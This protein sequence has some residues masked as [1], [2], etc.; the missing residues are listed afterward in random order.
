MT[1]AVIN[2]KVNAYFQ[3]CKNSDKLPNIAGLSLALG[4]P[5]RRMML[6]AARL[7]ST[8]EGQAVS[9]AILR[10]ETALEDRIIEQAMGARWILGTLPDYEQVKIPE[11][12]AE[13]ISVSIVGDDREEWDFPPLPLE[14]DS[15]LNIECDD[16]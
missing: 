15:D 11:Y 7:K 12:D 3:D 5:S 8:E 1:K 16:D 2:K 13:T 14:Q 4:Y 10:V 6:S 9:L